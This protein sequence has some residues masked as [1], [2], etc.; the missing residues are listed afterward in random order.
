MTIT[1]PTSW[2]GPKVVYQA[3]RDNQGNN[4][5]WLA[6]GVWRIPSPTQPVGVQNLTPARST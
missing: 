4:T 1:F 6:K 3:A 2:A 5:G